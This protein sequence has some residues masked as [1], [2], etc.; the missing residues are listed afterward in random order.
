MLGISVIVQGVG[1]KRGSGGEWGAGST[2]ASGGEDGD[3]EPVG[4]DH[5]AAAEA[6]ERNPMPRDVSFPT[7]LPAGRAIECSL[8]APKEFGGGVADA[9]LI[10]YVPGFQT[11]A[12]VR[13]GSKGSQA[14]ALTQLGPGAGPASATKSG[15]GVAERMMGVKGTSVRRGL[16]LVVEVHEEGIGG[17]GASGAGDLMA[18]GGLMAELRTNVCLQN[19]SASDVEVDIG[20]EAAAAVAV[21]DPGKGVRSGIMRE[22]WTPGAG[23]A[24]VVKLAPGARLALPLSVLASWQLRLVGDATDTRSRPLRLSPALLDPAVP[25]ALRLTG[26]MERNS[27][28][29]KVAKSGIAAAS[30]VSGSA[31]AA[32]AGARGEPYALGPASV[33]SPRGRKSLGGSPV[34]HSPSAETS[35]GSEVGMAS[36][37]SGSRSKLSPPPSPLPEVAHSGGADWVL[38]VQ[39]SY[40][41][42]NALPCTLEL[43]VLQPVAGAGVGGAESYRARSAAEDD[44]S[45]A[46]KPEEKEQPNDNISD[47]SS[48]ASSSTATT[49]RQNGKAAVA[50]KATLR[51]P[52]LDLFFLPTSVGPDDSGRLGGSMAGARGNEGRKSSDPGSGVRGDRSTVGRRDHHVLWLDSQKEESDATGGFK[53][54]WKGL[55]GSGQ[56]AKVSQEFSARVLVGVLLWTIV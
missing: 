25:N 3:D 12:G 1:G 31:A 55:V 52:A 40:L 47:V 11:I 49:A 43:E 33:L 14:Y 42:T 41:I 54:V 37:S 16:A 46:L 24:P 51:N 17:A 27:L 9:E 48:V 50:S 34:L 26:D 32:A 20:V 2:R 30:V 6:H 45:D 5:G 15:R 35:D 13:V 18:S 53:S 39:P 44:I 21:S 38:V 29:L 22:G 56:E 23:A 8:P 7:K 19:A 10:V 28:C 4:R 36:Q